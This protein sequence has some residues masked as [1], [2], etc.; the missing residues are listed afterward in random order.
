MPLWLASGP[1]V[2]ETMLAMLLVSG[3]P[4]AVKFLHHRCIAVAKLAGNRL[5]SARLANA[6]R[7][8]FGPRWRTPA[9]FKCLVNRSGTL[10]ARQDSPLTPKHK[11]RVVTFQGHVVT[12]NLSAVT[13][14]RVLVTARC[15]ATVP[16]L[17]RS[18]VTLRPRPRPLSPSEPPSWHA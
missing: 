6:C 18:A 15:C 16:A 4:A 2:G 8:R 13:I 10:E 1:I 9:R 17:V 11:T 14:G 7:H 3:Y 5:D 12:L